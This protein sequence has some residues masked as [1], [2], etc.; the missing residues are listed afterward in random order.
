MRSSEPTTVL[1]V[2]QTVP[3]IEQLVGRVLPSVRVVMALNDQIDSSQMTANNVLVLSCQK[4][5]NTI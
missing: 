3:H 2:H 1:Y 4:N 5:E